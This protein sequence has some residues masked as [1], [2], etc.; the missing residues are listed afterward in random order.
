[1][2]KLMGKN[3]LTILRSKFCSSSFM[4]SNDMTLYNSVSKIG[5]SLLPLRRGNYDFSLLKKVPK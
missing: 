3:L 2:L 4:L 1:M 5:T